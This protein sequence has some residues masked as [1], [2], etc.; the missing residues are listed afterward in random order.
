[1][2]V[3]AGVS[4]GGTAVG[5]TGVGVSVGTSVGGSTVGVSVGGAVVGVPSV[6]AIATGE[7]PP[8]VRMMVAKYSD[9]VTTLAAE[10]T[11]C[12]ARMLGPFSAAAAPRVPGNSDDCR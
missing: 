12:M 6:C 4:V 1:V 9:R 11:D 2:A 10:R 7:S 3:G 5:T 8:M